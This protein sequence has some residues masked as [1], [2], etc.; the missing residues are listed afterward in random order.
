MYQLG[1]TS[2]TIILQSC[3]CCAFLGHSFSVGINLIGVEELDLLNEEKS[4]LVENTS[5]Q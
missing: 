1:K 5:F 4:D 3:L 2:I